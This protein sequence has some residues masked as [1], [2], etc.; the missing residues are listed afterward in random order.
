MNKMK[1]KK[2]IKIKNLKE[3]KLMRNKKMKKKKTIKK[4][5]KNLGKNLPKKRKL[6]LLKNPLSPKKKYLLSN[7]ENGIIKFKIFKKN[8]RCWKALLTKLIALVVL[9]VQT[10]NFVELLQLETKNYY[11]IY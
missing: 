8:Q 3:K 1:N 6:L 2:M 9:P 5:A 7:L 4:R 11:K 10:K